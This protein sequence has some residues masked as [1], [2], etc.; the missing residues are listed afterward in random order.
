[1]IVGKFYYEKEL[2]IAALNRLLVIKN[3]YAD[4]NIID[5]SLYYLAAS[6]AALDQRELA[7]ETIAIL[8]KGYPQSPWLKKA[9]NL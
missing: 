1:L 8:E 3:A 2:Y 7:N 9:E 4:A 5:E 6:Y